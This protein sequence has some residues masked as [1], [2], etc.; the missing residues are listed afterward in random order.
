MSTLSHRHARQPGS[1]VSSAVDTGPV[2]NDGAVL[3]DL[4]NTTTR[5]SRS[6]LVDFT[7]AG[8]AMNEVG[9]ASSVLTAVQQLAAA[10][11][12]AV[13]GTIFFPRLWALTGASSS[14]WWFW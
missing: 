11:G 8:V 1:A 10:I 2:P 4:R 3:P 13:L 6:Q 5:L 9:S 7:L 12:V 14:G